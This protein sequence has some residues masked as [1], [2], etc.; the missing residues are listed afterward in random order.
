MSYR[1]LHDLRSYLDMLKKEGDL[2]VIDEEVDPY[3]EIAEI[4]V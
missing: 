4:L 2:L 1:K 3:L